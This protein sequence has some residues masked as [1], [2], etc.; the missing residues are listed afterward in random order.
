[1]RSRWIGALAA[2]AALAAPRADAQTPELQAAVDAKLAE[3]KP[4]PKGNDKA[5]G[6][7][8]RAPALDYLDFVFVASDRPVLVRLHMRNGERSYSAAWDDYMKKFFDYFDKNGDGKLSKA[9]V[10]RAPNAQFLQ[11]HL[12]GALGFP[13]QGQTVRLQDMDQNK[14]G[15]VVLDEFKDYYRKGGISPLQF[16]NN[17][18]RTATDRVT[19]TVFRYLDT[20]RD[21]KLSA[22]EMTHAP[23]ALRRVD[24]DEDEMLTAAELTPGGDSNNPYYFVDNGGSR[25]APTPEMGFIEIKPGAADAAAR[26]VLTLYDKNKNGKLSRDEIGLDKPLFDQLDV[27]HDDQLDA[28]EFAAFFRRDADLELL[29]RLGTANAAQQKVAGFLKSIGVPGQPVRAEIFNPDKRDMPLAARVKRQS[30][31]A[32]AMA[33]GDANIDL[34]VSDQMFAQFT[35]LKQFYTQQFKQADTDKKGVI[36]MKKAQTAQFLDQ[37]FPLADRDGDGKLT[38]KELTAYLDMQVQGSASQTQLTIT[39]TGRSLF[40]V[41]DANGDGRL[42]IRELRSAWERMKPLAKSAAGLSRGDVSR[43]LEVSLGAGQGRR[44]RPVPVA[45]GGMGR[46]AQGGNKAAPLWFTKMDRNGDGDISP[47][48]FIGRDEDFRKLD[49]DGDGLISAEEAR[50]FDEQLKKNKEVKR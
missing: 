13:L 17:N 27:N 25:G 19:N 36:D 42:S 7:P 2:C 10:E 30:P 37:I 34:S 24:L 41:L 38:E 29:G 47:R 50:Q 16:F 5:E 48:E 33:L 3:G 12:Q 31:V 35:N 8:L 46:P 23:E 14:D 4:A 44:G 11:I 20:N 28:R 15:E 26:Q 9:E 18:N 43:R 49:A 21:G 6:K 1:M 40:D 39:D 32:L 22:E 45:R